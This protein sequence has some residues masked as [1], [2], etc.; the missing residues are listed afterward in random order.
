MRTE[1]IVLSIGIAIVLIGMFAV[2]SAAED[3]A[4][5]EPVKVC[6]LV[7][8]DTIMLDSNSPIFGIETEVY[9]NIT[10][11]EI[12]G[13]TDG[14]PTEDDIAELFPEEYEVSDIYESDDIVLGVF[15]DPQY[16]IVDE[17]GNPVAGEVII[18]VD[19]RKP[20]ELSPHTGR[21]VM[22][23]ERSEVF[24]KPIVD[25]CE[26]TVGDLLEYACGDGTTG[27]VPFFIRGTFNKGE[28]EGRQFYGYNYADVMH[29][30]QCKGG[31]KKGG[32]KNS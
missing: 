3:P 6:I 15:V 9:E 28:Y 30:S 17:N 8:P 27:R 23:F 2:P 24:D 7:S 16:G 4:A 11:G 22:L 14:F 13:L 1:N 25:D 21:F 10:V 31:G 20:Y 32:G 5:E 18:D 26:V 29:K 12:I 19:T